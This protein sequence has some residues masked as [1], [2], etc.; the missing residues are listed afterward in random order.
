M[1]ESGRG[2]RQLFHVF[3]YGGCPHSM[4]I[5]VD[6]L[7]VGSLAAPSSVAA[8]DH[9]R[10]FLCVMHAMPCLFQIFCF[11]GDSSPVPLPDD[12]H[13][14]DPRN[15]PKTLLASFSLITPTLTTLE[16]KQS[17]CDL[18]NPTKSSKTFFAR[19]CCSFSTPL[20]IP[21]LIAIA[22]PISTP[23]VCRGYKV[24]SRSHGHPLFPSSRF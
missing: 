9:G 12:A 7:T 15:L 8:L 22:D 3:T 6:P 1:S 10:F 16:A 21:K 14:S 11:L 17:V 19:R 24:G 2:L 23:T 5:G 13:K 18:A 4:S 20:P